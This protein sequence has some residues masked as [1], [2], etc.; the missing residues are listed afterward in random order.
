M[1]AANIADHRSAMRTAVIE[2]AEP[3]FVVTHDDNLAAADTGANIIAGPGHFAFVPGVH[4][5]PFENPLHF[6]VEYIGIGIDPP[7]HPARLDQTT[8]FIVGNGVHS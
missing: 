7:V 3:A 5:G 6:E 1:A 2:S 8:D 4:P